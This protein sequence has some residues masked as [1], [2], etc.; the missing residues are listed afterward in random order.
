MNPYE[1]VAQTEKQALSV[2]QV[3]L[4]ISLGALYTL[5][6]LLVLLLAYLPIRYPGLSDKESGPAYYWP[7][8]LF[9]LL[10]PVTSV[11]LVV[12]TAVFLTNHLW[13]HHRSKLNLES[14]A[15]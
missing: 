10:L 9:Y 6:G 7:D 2:R 4:V 12:S 5:T 3:V 15:T 14:T 8:D 11:L 1:P 13:K